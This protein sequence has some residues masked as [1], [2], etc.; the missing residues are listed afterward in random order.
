MA[1]ST[2]SSSPP[3]A[4]AL[5]ERHYPH[6]HEAE[7]AVLGCLL[8]DPA[9]AVDAVVLRL[10]DESSFHRAEHQV[11]YR[12]IK[13]QIDAGGRGD[14][15]L[16]T[17]ADIL[18]RAGQLEAA[19][20]R[21]YLAQ[22]STAVATAANVEQ[23]AEIVRQT[24]VL[25]RLITT[26]QRTSERCFQPVEDVR[27]LLDDIEREILSVTALHETGAV[28][29]V[30]EL[31][32]PAVEYLEKLQK[33]ESEALGLSTGY[34]D[35]D[36]LITGLRPGEMV[37]VAARPSIG[38]TALALN[39]A[40]NIAMGTPPRAVGLFSLEMPAHQVVLR[41]LCS[42]ARIGLSEVRE[43]AMTTARWK[44]LMAASQRL[45]EAT[46]VIDD[47][48]GIDILEL[49]N[50][51]RRMKRDY[52]IDVLFIDY[53]QL[54]QVSGS[55]RNANRENEVAR[56]SGSIK[57]LAK[58]LDIPIVVLAQLNRQAEQQGQ[59]PRLSHL[60][61]SGAIEQDADVV[62][63]LH[64]DRDEQQDRDKAQRGVE[65][66]LIVAKNRN[67]ETGLAHLIFR[68]VYTRFESH[69]RIADE[70]VPSV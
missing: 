51:A 63:L 48:G 50:K 13:A 45:R 65:A 28:R 61:E 53:L 24:A 68:P 66:E 42:D 25:R 29:T 26:C 38:K 5:T 70:D 22:V 47:T 43:G 69:S 10:P 58:E 57:A 41:L 1:S 21:A 27:L 34:D 6:N 4:P 16:I 39:M 7:M 31:M 44:E 56:I 14:L 8:L 23:Y 9:A 19:G 32:M 15:D 62:A 49:R 12:A 30:A 3:A 11:I 20:G 33:G 18:A 40:A 67:G 37:V 36:R 54:I 59:R 64:R 2:T 60:R 17:L 35:I 52:T 55:N 46:I